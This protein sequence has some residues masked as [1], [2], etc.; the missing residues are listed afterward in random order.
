MLEDGLSSWTVDRNSFP[1]F[2]H[3]VFLL[4]VCLFVC[5]FVFCV[6]LFVLRFPHGK[7]EATKHSCKPLLLI[8]IGRKIQL[9]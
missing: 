6:C 4:L 7:P 1:L 2:V 8:D 3:N 9:I 5:L